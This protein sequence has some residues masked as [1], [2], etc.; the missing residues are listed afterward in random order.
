MR[1]TLRFTVRDGMVDPM[2]GTQPP[3]PA[4][5]G[6]RPRSTPV[7][8]NLRAELGAALARER[9]ESIAARADVSLATVLRARQGLP[10]SP[11][12]RA[13][14]ARAVN[15]NPAVAA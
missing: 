2:E 11:L 5:P 13:A 4:A 9:P 3:T 10:V 7:D 8:P 1:D 12:V 15:P 6:K 14:L